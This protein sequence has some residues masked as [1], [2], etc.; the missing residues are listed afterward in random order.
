MKLDV[1]VVTVTV[2]VEEEYLKALAKK[3]HIMALHINTRPPQTI[4]SIM[5]TCRT[6]G[7]KNYDLF[8]LFYKHSI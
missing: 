6:I 7:S 4:R 1:V 2:A 3:V 8:Y 5:D